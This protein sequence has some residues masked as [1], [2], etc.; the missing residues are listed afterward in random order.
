MSVSVDYSIE[1]HLRNFGLS[2]LTKLVA[3]RMEN[4][5]GWL[6]QLYRTGVARKVRKIQRVWKVW[7][8]CKFQNV[9]KVWKDLKVQ[10]VREV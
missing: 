2:R 1:N 3:I 7:K 4:L 9:Q 10:E 8:I 6:A 5:I